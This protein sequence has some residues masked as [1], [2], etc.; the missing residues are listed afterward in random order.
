MHKRSRLLNAFHKS[1]LELKVISEKE[2]FGIEDLFYYNEF[3]PGSKIY[4]FYLKE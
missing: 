3:F 4:N 1:E 2:C